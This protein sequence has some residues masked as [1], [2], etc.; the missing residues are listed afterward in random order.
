MS[1]VIG[2]FLIAFA[3]WFIP[4]WTESPEMKALEAAVK[5]RREARLAYEAREAEA[6][7]LAEEQGLV[8]LPVPPQLQDEARKQGVRL[9]PDGTPRPQ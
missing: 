1:L 3:V 2:A 7:R 8:Y 6:K 5:E 4:N 9:N